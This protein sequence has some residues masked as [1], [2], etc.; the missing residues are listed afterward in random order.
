MDLHSFLSP[1]LDV[2]SFAIH[3]GVPSIDRFMIGK[4]P[5]EIV[6]WKRRSFSRRRA[7]RRRAHSSQL[8]SKSI[9]LA[10]LRALCYES[11]FCAFSSRAL[12]SYRLVY[13]RSV[14][15]LVDHVFMFIHYF[16]DT[17]LFAA[18]FFFSSTQA[19]TNN[20]NKRRWFITHR[21]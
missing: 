9:E 4:R 13:A 15:P 18:L 19:L 10:R 8:I 21:T 11:F 6:K 16:I 5:K 17:F 12:W 14:R 1:P 20:N 7:R 2:V 3:I